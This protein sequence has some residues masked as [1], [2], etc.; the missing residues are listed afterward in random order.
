MPRRTAARPAQIRQRDAGHVVLQTYQK[1]SVKLISPWRPMSQGVTAPSGGC[2]RAGLQA[3]SYRGL[4]RTQP[5]RSCLARLRPQPQH[6][7]TPPAYCCILA[8]SAANDP[9]RFMAEAITIPSP[10]A[11]L[12]SPAEAALTTTSPQP[13]P[14]RRSPATPKPKPPLAEAPT[15]SKTPPQPITKRKQSKSRNGTVSLLSRL[16]LSASVP[17]AESTLRLSLLENHLLTPS[18]PGCVTCKA[19]R[20]KCDETKPT[21]QQ[22]ARRSVP[23]GGYKKDFKWRPFEEANFVGN[24]PTAGK[25]RKASPSPAQAQNP[26]A[27]SRSPPAAERPK[28]TFADDVPSR[29]S[30]EQQAPVSLP[31]TSFMEISFPSPSSFFPPVPPLFQDPMD[32]MPFADPFEPGSTASTMSMFNDAETVDTMQSATTAPS[33]LSSGQSPRLVD[34]LLPGADLNATSPAFLDWHAQYSASLYH[35]PPDQMDEEG[36]VEEI[37]RQPPINPDHE[38]WVMRLPSPERESSSGSSE[39][40]LATPRSD[41]FDVFLDGPRLPRGSPEMVTLRFD[42]ETCGIL[43]LKDG[44]SENPWR[45]MIWP[46]ARDCPALYHAIASM[47]SF[48]TAKREPQLRVCGIEH[49][50]TS[51][52]ALATGI[53]NMR[54]ET[55]IATTLALAFS[56]SWDQHTSTGI[57]HIKGAKILVN[58]AL[59]KHQ[60]APL[61]GQ[62][63]T[64]LKFLCNTWIYMDVIA[65]LTSV[66]ADDSNDFDTIGSMFNDPFEYE[67]QHV[68]PLMGC[69]ATLFPIIGRVAN[70]VRRVRRSES[71]SPAIISQAMEL[72]TRLEDWVPQAFFEVPEDPTSQVQHSLQTAEAY[73]WAT[74]L[75]LHQAVPEIPSLSSAELSKKVLVY[76]ATVPLSSRTIIVHIYPLTAAGCEAADEEDRQWVRD[77]WEAMGQRMVIGIIDRCLDICREVWARRDA[78]EARIRP[79]AKVATKASLKRNVIGHEEHHEDD[80]EPVRWNENFVGKRR[81]TIGPFEM[82]KAVH[83]KGQRRNSSDNTGVVNREF[84]VRGRL[85]WLGVMK[86]WGWEGEFVSV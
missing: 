67:S 64:R 10:S 75:Y 63:L 19:K 34:L 82:P 29:S 62:E 8:L 83:V 41:P 18:F 23:C 38:A 40:G 21:C 77:R 80:D 48:H 43:S 84:T 30:A 44:P 26:S 1:A 32:T 37:F 71:N 25:Q 45:T 24:K 65:R 9:L 14:R 81:A 28:V 72:K 54:F 57:D 33:S 16:V 60:R 79:R 39:G 15:T 27:K 7:G 78:Y 35:Q 59:I 11:F 47:T 13:Q 53:Q 12:S 58:Q 36:D 4:H 46:L 52:E 2:L 17:P 76:L 68:D 70:L 69:A 42:Q 49:M 51:I 61:M 86:D 22:C 56:E 20:L 31:P 50:R 5:P 73:R 3:G 6:S 74:L 85:H 55:A 66:D